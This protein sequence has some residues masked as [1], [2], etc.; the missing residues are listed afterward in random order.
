MKANVTRIIP[1]NAEREDV[2]CYH[3]FL[4]FERETGI[5]SLWFSYEGAFARLTALMKYHDINQ[6]ELLTVILPPYIRMTGNYFGPHDA[7]IDYLA[8][9]PGKNAGTKSQTEALRRA[10]KNKKHKQLFSKERK[11][12][13]LP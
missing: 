10:V 12:S 13:S 5:S 2:R 7:V 9:Y 3:E 11:T 4:I 1:L 6:H 8:G